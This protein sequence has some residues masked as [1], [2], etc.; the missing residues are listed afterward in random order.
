MEAAAVSTDGVVFLSRLFTPGDLILFRPV[1]TWTD[2]NGKRVS[3]VVQREARYVR[4]GAKDG[5]GE[6]VAMPGRLEKI[7]ADFDA[8]AARERANQ[9]FG[10]CPRQ[11]GDGKFDRAWQIRTVRALWSDVDGKAASEVTAKLTE[12]KLPPPSM[13]VRSGNGVHLYWLLGEP[14][15]LDDYDPA[16]P[17]ALQTERIANGDGKKRPR[18]Y[19]LDG[20]GE[21]VY[22]SAATTPDL[23]IKAL[24]AQNI[25]AG[26]AKLIGGDHTQDLARLLRIPGTLNRKNE[27]N[28]TTPRPCVLETCEPE[29][30]YLLEEFAFCEQFSE[31]YKVRKR[32]S[33][34]K[35][36]PARKITS[37]GLSRL[38]DLVNDCIAA[39]AGERSE[40]DY[41]LCCVAIE[42]GWEKETVWQ[43]VQGAGKFAEAGRRY[44][45]M[46][47][48]KAENRTREKIFTQRSKKAGKKPPP[49]TEVT[50]DVAS[51]VA[52]DTAPDT[53]PAATVAPPSKG[54]VAKRSGVVD[55][56]L[57]ANRAIEDEIAEA[58]QIDVLGE[59]SGDRPHPVLFSLRHRKLVTIGDIGTLRYPNLLQICGD[60]AKER[61][62]EASTEAP[63][64]MYSFRDVKNA[65]AYL[66]GLQRIADFQMTGSGVWPGIDFD[67]DPDGTVVLVGVGEGAV[68]DGD[69]RVSR[70]IHPRCNGR[71]LEFESN[72]RD[73]WYDYAFLQKTLGDYTQ[74]WAESVIDECSTLFARWRWAHERM[75]VLA[76][77]LVMTTWLQTLWDW[78]P[79]VEVTGATSTGKSMLLKTIGEM[80]GP[81]CELSSRSS[82][83]G[84]RQTIQQSG[85]V[86]MMDEFEKSRE[87]EKVLEYVRASSRGDAVLMGQTHQKVK[88]FRLQHVIWVGAIETGLIK[89]AD[90][91]RFVS[92]ELLK[93]LPGQ[94]GRLATP[95]RPELWTL[96]QQLLAIG[97]RNAMAAKAMAIRLKSVRLEGVD[98]RY[99]ESYSVPAAIITCAVGGDDAMATGFLRQI[100]ETMSDDSRQ[101]SDEED[102][103][104]DV[105]RSTIRLGP[106]EEYSVVRMLEQWREREDF[107]EALQ[108]NGIGLQYSRAGRSSA[109]WY[110]A[111]DEWLFLDSKDVSTKLLAK[112]A[113]DEWSGKN[114]ANIL[115]RISGARAEQRSLA[116][117]RVY[118]VLIPMGTIRAKF[119]GAGDD[120][121]E[122]AGMA[123]DAG[124]K[125]RE[126]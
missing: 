52:S 64:G 4:L 103:L 76:T 107:R 86:V 40:M 101:V 113:R 62:F 17:P 36:P 87:R 123:G 83:A 70:V 104:H 38:S 26:I 48:A 28:G 55:G 71:I 117:R 5:A 100:M 19:F 93:P 92:L 94:E 102:L 30:Q 50:S 14:Y 22:L 78:R 12:A 8:V 13:V 10:V 108:R 56:Q 118:G 79:M 9:F 119:F 59:L 27:R 124:V 99:I 97:L 60:P 84:V 32:I 24:R 98:A 89:A 75:P 65:I 46:T 77:G 47:W 53:A 81:L 116:G 95:G 18:R 20:D 125:A 69:G 6:W 72:V 45:D 115:R 63:D 121:E 1:E 39:P 96:G 16:D 2:E 35:L 3:R 54:G 42:R 67:G 114:L 73:Q 25:V 33:Q 120:G 34:I 126:F 41:Y 110:G 106:S 91:N 74:K 112:T 23:S 51:D 31:E 57:A 122:S 21:P 43:E 90:R 66:A 88:R 7:L 85:K 15:N 49:V 11:G 82:A 44:F 58:L 111:D 105:L 61:V 37:A 109:S 80:L 29:R 68:V